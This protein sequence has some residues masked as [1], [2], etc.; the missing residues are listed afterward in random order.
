M[1]DIQ[2]HHVARTSSNPQAHPVRAEARG[3]E[4]AYS[5]LLQQR[6]ARLRRQVRERR[7]VGM[8]RRGI[9]CR[10]RSL[11]GVGIRRHGCK[12]PPVA[13]SAERLIYSGGKV[14]GRAILRQHPV[15][16][17]AQRGERLGA[18]GNGLMRGVVGFRR[19]SRAWR[20]F[21]LTRSDAIKAR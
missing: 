20:V 10:Q 17:G 6:I 19:P 15:H 7:R 18:D 5:R 11:I 4:R 9:Q 12:A 1:R 16:D 21:A 2:L 8:L 13:A 14:D 3:I